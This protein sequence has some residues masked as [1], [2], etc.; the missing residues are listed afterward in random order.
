MTEWNPLETRV[1]VCCRRCGGYLD[2]WVPLV[3]PFSVECPNGCGVLSLDDSFGGGR[4]QRAKA[5][6][7][8]KGRP[9]RTIR[10]TPRSVR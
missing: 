2:L 5:R 10:V 6:A 4:N 1:R 3:G 8:A 9:A 7:I